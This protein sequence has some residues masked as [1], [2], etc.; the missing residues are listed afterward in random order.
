MDPLAGSAMLH[1]ST[2]PRVSFQTQVIQLMSKKKAWSTEGPSP[3][4]E[5]Q[6]FAVNKT[7]QKSMRLFRQNRRA[8]KWSDPLRNVA[9]RPYRH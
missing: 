4:P 1:R 3:S 7:P 2:S 5:T 8:A 6:P 9:T